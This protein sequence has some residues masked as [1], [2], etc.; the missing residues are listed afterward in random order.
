MVMLIMKK[1][2]PSG[3]DLRGRRFVV[4]LDLEHPVQS[5]SSIASSRIERG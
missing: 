5:T 3:R 2:V 4:A 1:Y